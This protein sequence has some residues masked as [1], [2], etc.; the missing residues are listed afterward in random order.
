MVTHVAVSR[1]DRVLSNGKYSSPILNPDDLRSIQ[2]AVWNALGKPEIN[3]QATQP[4]GARIEGVKATEVE[5][6]T[7]AIDITTTPQ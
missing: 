6:V 3:I 2:L 7:R 1:L 5:I 4:N